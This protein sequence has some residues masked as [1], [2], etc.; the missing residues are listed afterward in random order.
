M[1]E[2]TM[3]QLKQ[4]R[5][6]VFAQAL[7]EQLESTQYAELSFEERLSMLVDRE[8]LERD[9]RRK[10]RL[11]KNAQLKH[12]PT[13]ED[14]D[15]DTPRG[16]PRA[17]VMELSQCSWVKRA[18]N[19][20][21]TGPTGVG[22]TF[23]ASAIAKRACAMECTARYG[24]TAEFVRQ[25]IIAK[26]DGS[27]PKLMAK[28]SRIQLLVCDEWLRDPLTAEQAREVLDLLD[29]RFRRASTVFV[30]QLP[31]K[32]WHRM[33]SDPTIADAVLD[34]VVH[35]SHRIELAGESMRKHTAKINSPE[36]L[37]GGTSLRSDL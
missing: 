17:R 13:L 9:N 6:G 27:Y 24:K 20:I 16:L 23:L 18:H 10:K 22:K 31:V 3:T 37:T 35:D 28:L 1:I 8:C 29:E 30:S 12:H 15:F 32:E 19:L 21:I 26:H 7:R 25:L 5:L 4:L 2:Q 34:R 14:I 33:I 36:G 11:V